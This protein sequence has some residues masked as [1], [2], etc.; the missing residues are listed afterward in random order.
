[1]KIEDVINE[2]VIAIYGSPSLAKLLVL[3]GGCAMRMFDEHNTRLSIDAD[4]SIED[5][6]TDTDPVFREMEACF[7]TRFATHGFD[8]LDFKAARKPKKLR[9]GFPAWWGGWACEFKLV[10][11][12]HR[13]KSLETRRRNAL[14]PAGA[15]SPKI[16]IDLS[17]HEYC[18]KPRTKT[19]HGT[20]IRGYSSEML[21]LEKLRAICQ[22]HP[23]YPYRQQPK[24]RARDFYD[25]STLTDDT[26]DKFIRCC[27]DHLK[28]VFKAK[29]VPQWILRA[30]WDDDAFVDEFR[31]GFDQVK[32][33]V[34]GRLDD[35]NTYLEHVRFLVRDV[36][37]DLPERPT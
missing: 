27:Q 2:V 11:K 32:T 13:K 19:F 10:E 8:L 23:D 25:I 29:E 6:L 34:R 4:F 36:C 24:N 5:V 15:N 18:G 22:Q 7:T 35:F 9:R 12:K 30:L 31:L 33:T 37:P 20:S 1:M 14:I 17:E 26:S 21:V 3:K 28:A 16:Q